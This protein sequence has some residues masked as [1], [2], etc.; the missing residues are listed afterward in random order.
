MHGEG[1]AYASSAGRNG[2]PVLTRR[3]LYAT[4]CLALILL[5]LPHGGAASSGPTDLTVHHPLTPARGDASALTDVTAHR[6]RRAGQPAATRPLGWQSMTYSGVAAA[7]AAGHTRARVPGYRLAYPPQWTARLWP[8]TL[9]GYGQLH[10]YAP[11]GP[12]LDLTLLPLRP[13]GPTLAALVAHD[14]AFLAGATRSWVT[15]P[16]GPA[17]RLS[18]RATPLSTGMASQILY[19]ARPGLVYRLFFSHPAASPVPP[20]L[21]V[22]VAST[23]RALVPTGAASH[24]PPGPPAPPS[25]TCCHCPVWGTG[26]GTVLTQLDGIPVYWNAGN[27]DNGCVGTYGIPYQC[28]ELVQRYFALRWGYP[29]IWRGVGG[30]ADMRWTH[31]PDI[32]FIPN[33]GAPG[34]RAGDA[35]LFY[36]GGVGHVALVSRVDQTGGQITVVEG[37][38]SPTGEA[39]L[40]LYGDNVI[41]IRDNAYGSYTIAGWLHSPRNVSAAR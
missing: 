5:G 30:A 9:A 21:L 18:G 37:N 13:H 3:R 35:L 34:P 22:Q 15:L 41:G 26:W 8:D 28:V 7:P 2:G 4:A 31:P 12:T 36:G 23:L 10:L 32:A 20:A 11:T 40:P 38:W 27:V 25:E 14:R 29:A 24:V 39:T 19:I 17:L 16:L 33:G 1:G 6:D